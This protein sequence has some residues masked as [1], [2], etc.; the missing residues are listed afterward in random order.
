MKYSIECLVLITCKVKVVVLLTK[1]AFS[2]LNC[3]K[4]E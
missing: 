3:F 1:T 4:A 2:I